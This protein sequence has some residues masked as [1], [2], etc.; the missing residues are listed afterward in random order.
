MPEPYP[1]VHQPTSVEPTESPTS[2][3][4]LQPLPNPNASVEDEGSGQLDERSLNVLAAREISKWQMEMSL[5]PLSPPSPP[6]AGGRSVSPRLSFTSEIPPYPAR[7]GLVRSP[8]TPPPQFLIRELTPSPTQPDDVY[9]TPPE[10]LRNSSA[11]P[12]PPMTSVPPPPPVPQVTSTSSPSPPTQTT[13]KKLSAATFR[14]TGMRGLSRN[15]NLG[16]GDKNGDGGPDDAVTPLNL[17]RKSLPVVPG[18]STNSSPSPPTQ[19]TLKKISAAAF[20]R[21]GVRGLSSNVNLGGGDEN[22]DEGPDDAVTPLNLRKKSLPA[23]P[24]VSTN[25][26]SGPRGPGAA[27]STSSPFPSLKASGEQPLGSGRTF[28]SSTSSESRP[29]ESVLG[30]G[31]EDFDYI[32][33]YLNDYEGRQSVTPNGTTH[34][35]GPGISLPQNGG[36]ESGRFATR[37]ED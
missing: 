32:S 11:P 24:G 21:A 15:V 27:R 35:G 12:S 6:F 29:Q 26:L 5:P 19:T 23:V 8:S 14:R 30:G 4:G 31:D 2:T 16:G 34:G 7:A 10:Y 25:L 17:R 20:R 13:P 1:H 28:P 18:V 22:G 37:L 3:D 36:Y 33:A 9:N